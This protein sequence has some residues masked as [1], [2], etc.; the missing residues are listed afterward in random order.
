M[1]RT[2]RIMNARSQG[3]HNEFTP[4]VRSLV[5]YYNINHNKIRTDTKVRVMMSQVNDMKSVMGKNMKLLINRSYDV[6]HLATKSSELEEKV[7]VF[8]KRARQNLRIQQRIYYS[9]S[10]FLCL[11]IVFCIYIGISIP[12][13][14]TFRRCYV[15]VNNNRRLRY[16]VRDITK[17]IQTNQT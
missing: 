3:L 11:L 1:F 17:T 15:K 5:H 7:Q 12:C 16:V 6:N 4:T 10:L 13:G 8:K 14:L 9:K 2:R